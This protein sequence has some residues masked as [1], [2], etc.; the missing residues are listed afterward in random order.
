MNSK[1]P[2]CSLTLYHRV[3]ETRRAKR[4]DEIRRRWRCLKHGVRWTTW[5]EA[6]S[7]LSPT[8]EEKGECKA[9]SVSISLDSD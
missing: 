7:S 4:T 9:A 8:V 5:D 2:C 1:K 6:R 3:I